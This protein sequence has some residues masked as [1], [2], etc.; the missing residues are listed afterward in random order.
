MADTEFNLTPTIIGSM[1]HR[2]PVAACKLISRYL[3]ELPA[4]PQ[5]PQRTNRELMT[6]QFAEGFPGI[7]ISDENVEVDRQIGW[8][9]ELEALYG[10]YINGDTEKYGISPEVAAGFYAFLG[11]HPSS[12]RGVKGQ[13][14]GPISW[15]LSVKDESGGLL[16]YDDVMAEAAAKLLGLKI[17][18]QENQLRN[19]SPR[20]V[21]FLDEP[22]LTAYGSA[23]LPLSKE[24]I[25]QML[26][27]VL[28]EIKGLKG[29]HCCGN[30]DWTILT[31]LALDIISFDAY[32]YGG[33]LSLY[34]DEVSRFLARGGAVAWGIAPNT[35]K[36]AQ[37]ETAASLQDRLE[38]AMAPFTRHGVNFR[39]LLRQGLITPSCGMA[40]MSEDGAER[41]LEL[42]AELTARMRSRYL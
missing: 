12:P 38:E 26:T 7:K 14:A 5:L 24:R 10:A 31:G 4:W 15:G 37:S 20:T 34:P 33:S 6:A 16:I 32:N 40:Y 19:I 8:E 17:A 39:Q 42:M 1:P 27:E 9:H 25:Q 22:A 11:T 21:I 29:I 28:G 18:W 36:L 41:T 3:T 23:Y 35:D 30:T 13:V 2:D